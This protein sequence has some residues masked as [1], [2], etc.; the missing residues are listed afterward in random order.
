MTLSL[1]IRFSQ[2]QN[3][4]CLALP[5]LNKHGA[6]SRMLLLLFQRGF[7]C[8]QTSQKLL[9][10]RLFLLLLHDT[11]R[12][13]HTAS[14]TDDPV[15]PALPLYLDPLLPPSAPQ[16]T[17]CC[18]TGDTLISLSYLMESL[19]EC[20]ILGWKN[21]FM[22][23]FEVKVVII[24]QLS[25]AA[26]EKPSAMVIVILEMCLLFPLRISGISS[27]PL[28]LR[29]H[30]AD[31][32]LICVWCKMEFYRLISFRGKSSTVAFILS[33]PPL[34]SGRRYWSGLGLPG[35]TLDDPLCCLFSFSP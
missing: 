17:L 16:P 30:M 13:G 9:H 26:A 27:P 12:L 29:F 4:I 11:A 19:A 28:A 22:L 3:K 23:S 10:Q 6:G 31:P 21:I 14:R 7:F 25:T 33:S 32:G 35:L 20:T 5:V 2:G 8:T 1:L 18:I 34:P 24:F 15:P